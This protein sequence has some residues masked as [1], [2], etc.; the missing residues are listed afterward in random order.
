MM[1]LGP[2]PHSNGFI[3]LFRWSFEC[4]EGGGSVG[5][6]VERENRL[7]LC[8]ANCHRRF[9]IPSLVKNKMLQNLFWNVVYEHEFSLGEARVMPCSSAHM[10]SGT[11]RKIKFIIARRVC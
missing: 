11:K 8:C 3:A 9:C 5:G 2:L 4:C 10:S 6:D 1:H 7:H